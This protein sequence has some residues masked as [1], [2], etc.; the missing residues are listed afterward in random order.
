MLDDFFTRVKANVWMEV[1]GV[2]DKIYETE[3]VKKFFLLFGHAAANQAL[4]VVISVPR[5]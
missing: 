3:R 5:P 2:L 4:C 1:I